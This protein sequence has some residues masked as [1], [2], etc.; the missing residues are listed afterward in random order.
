MSFFFNFYNENKLKPNLKMAVSRFQILSSKKSN[1]VKA[2]KKEIAGLLRTSP[3]PKEE[4]ARIRAEALIREDNAIEAYEILELQCDL[5]CERIKLI[6]AEKQCPGDLLSCVSTL[7]WASY[8]IDIPELGVV[9][10]QFQAKYGKKFIASA[11]A[12]ENGVLNDRVVH[13]LAVKPPNAFLVES[14]LKEIA[15]ENNI[16]WE[17]K[18]IAVNK[19]VP[20]SAPTGFSI[21]NAP[22]SDFA[23][24]HV[25]QPEPP[26]KE[27]VPEGWSYTDDGL[28]VIDLGEEPTK[29]TASAET[30]APPATT[31]IITT[32]T[33]ATTTNNPKTDNYDDLASRFAALKK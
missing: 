32:T 30:S 24:C 13:K 8:Q 20:M 6:S 9:R 4:K 33:T 18:E 27:N 28:L 19:N 17:P 31:E 10:S 26:K 22:G 12:N 14:Y 23:S 11:M 5:L 2:N 15:I 3:V 16:D 29:P 21:P 1:L 7:I 25:V